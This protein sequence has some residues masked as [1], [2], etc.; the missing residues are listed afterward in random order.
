MIC[1]RKCVID[2][3]YK[4]FVRN[5]YVLYWLILP[6]VKAYTQS[7]L[8]LNGSSRLYFENVILLFLDVTFLQELHSI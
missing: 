8:Q 4:V 5:I 6:I 1:I 2:I 7:G 3:I